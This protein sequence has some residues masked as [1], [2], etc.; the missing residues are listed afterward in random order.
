MPSACTSTSLILA[1]A[2]GGV[3]AINMTIMPAIAA[4]M[5]TRLANPNRQHLNTAKGLNMAIW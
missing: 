1:E 5:V 2:D 4:T 3:I